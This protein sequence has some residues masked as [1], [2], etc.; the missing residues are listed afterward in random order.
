MSTNRNTTF[1]EKI[2][3]NDFFERI[4]NENLWFWFVKIY[5]VLLIQMFYQKINFDLIFN[6]C[7][8]CNWILKMLSKLIFNYFINFFYF[9]ITY[10]QH[11]KNFVDV[12]KLQIRFVD[13]IFIMFSFRVYFLNIEKNV[14]CKLTD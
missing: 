14:K 11:C 3:L 12:L 7:Q 9:W 2:F 4:F 10:F 8:F 1:V 5:V 6:Y 13:S